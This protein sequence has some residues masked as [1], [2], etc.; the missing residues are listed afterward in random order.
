MYR[1][2]GTNEFIWMQSIAT[3]AVEIHQTFDPP[4]CRLIILANVISGPAS[5]SFDSIGNLNRA[6]C[7]PTCRQ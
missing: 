2:L 6:I 7:D 5:L 4:H 1:L 3:R